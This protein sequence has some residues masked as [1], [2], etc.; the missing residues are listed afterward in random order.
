MAL[1][2]E[3]Y[4]VVLSFAPGLY[5][6]DSSERDR[7][8]RAGIPDIS[9]ASFISTGQLSMY[10]DTAL[11]LDHPS[12]DRLYDAESFLSVYNLLSRSFYFSYLRRSHLIHGSYAL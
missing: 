1:N 7:T 10:A 11:G 8:V 6:F 12:G 5:S 4:I 2:G 3:G 9:G